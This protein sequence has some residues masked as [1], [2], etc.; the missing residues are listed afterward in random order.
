MASRTS[1]LRAL[2]PRRWKRLSSASVF[3]RVEYVERSS[4]MASLTR[5]RVT[6]A[7][8]NGT[9]TAFSATSTACSIRVFI[10][11]LASAASFA[12]AVRARVASAFALLVAVERAAAPWLAARVCAAFFAVVERLTAFVLRV[13]AA[14]FAATLG[15]AGG[16]V[17]VS[18]MVAMPPW[19]DD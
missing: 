1:G 14:F 13:T 2:E 7:A 3:L 18:A 19:V 6:S 8:P 16:V 15:S 11:L 9:R 12:A 17:V 4:S 10:A 5:S